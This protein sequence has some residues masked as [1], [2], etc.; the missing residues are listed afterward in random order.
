[1]RAEELALQY[2]LIGRLYDAALHEDHWPGVC[3]DVA[4][5]FGASNAAAL[6]Q[7]AGAG[8]VVACG[9]RSDGLLTA[10]LPHLERAQQLRS[11][12][13][14]NEMAERCSVAALDALATAVVL[15]DAGLTVLYANGAAGT[16]F[17]AEAPLQLRGARLAQGGSRGAQTLAHMVRR[18]VR[19]LEPDTLSGPAQAPQ[20]LCLPRSG[21]LPLT[22]S[23]APFMLGGGCAEGTPCAIIMARDPETVTAS[24]EVLQQLFQL[25]PAEAAV[26]RALAGGASL[27][28]IAAATGV[29]VNTVKTHLHRVYGKTATR[30]QGELIA[31]IHG[32]TATLLPPHPVG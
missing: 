19:C 31:L 8:G 28:D 24:A 29:S 22:L 6:L 25:T 21:H 5:A 20:S 14:H 1:M 12:L 7:P 32:S 26:S 17:G 30:R 11:R 10:F 4:A 3:A 16:L 18:A 15:L 23:V 9:G 13:A 2:D 27:E